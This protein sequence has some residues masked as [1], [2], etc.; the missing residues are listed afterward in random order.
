M[1][2]SV[3]KDGVNMNIGDKIKQRRL[4]LDLS[5]DE[6]AK[7][8]N[9]N[10]ATIYR[11][12]N[13]EIENLPLSTLEPLADALETTPAYLMGWEE[14][15][16]SVDLD[17]FEEI[18]SS[19]GWWYETFSECDGLGVNEYLDDEDKIHCGSRTSV[20][21]C[22]PCKFY[23]PYYY[24]TNGDKYYK[25]SKEEFDNLSSCLKPYL[26]FRI[27]ELISRKKGL[28]EYEYQIDESLINN[29]DEL[30]DDFL[31]NNVPNSNDTTSL[32]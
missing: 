22:Y 11:Y 17:F 19:I 29:P 14:K 32:E 7:K 10:R 16:S 4:E 28:T 26:E 18:L 9:K 15:H 6:L 1:V 20:D 12:E 2:N 3:H 27:N 25:L 8:I 24:L 21:S 30:Q 31:P 23:Q 13:N 5:V